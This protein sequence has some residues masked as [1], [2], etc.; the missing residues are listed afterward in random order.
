M[1]KCLF[2]A[3]FSF[4]PGIE[5][6]Y[7]AVL[8][9]EFKEIWKRDELTPDPELTAWAMNP[10]QGF[11]VTDEVLDLFPKLK[12]ISSPSTGTNHIDK[13]AC[14][15]RGISVYCLLD[16]RE[17]LETISAS[18]EFTFLLLLNALRRLDVAVG[19][20]PAGRWR[21]REDDM[22]G[23]E[24]YGKKVGVIGLG[25]IGR[26]MTRYCQAFDA[27][28]VYWDPY[29]ENAD[30]PR[31]SMESIFSQ[32]DVV[33]SCCVLTDET[34]NMIGRSLL[35]TLKPRAVFVNTS[36]G[37]V[38]NEDDLAFVVT[39]R[40]DIRVAVDVICGEVTG[41]QLSSPLIP[42]HNSQRIVIAPHIAG[43]TTESQQKAALIALSLLNRHFDAVRG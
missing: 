38:V 37:E 17:K 40:P 13:E 19:E 11:I 1:E 30:I 36:R 7:R 43:V 14:A 28:V 16:D 24:L 34:R 3:P 15:R 25:R 33:V 4:I 32:C 2:S 35:E 20:V 26:R 23:N 18:A 39:Q 29:V 6:D 22:R 41:T 10:G 31:V 8:P 21:E 42:F 12:V 27:D 5:K 9:T